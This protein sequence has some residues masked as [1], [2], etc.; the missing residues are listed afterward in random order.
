MCRMARSKP[1]SHPGSR[2]DAM[3]RGTIR[4]VCEKRDS[5]VNC[6]SRTP[7]SVRWTALLDRAMACR[8]CRLE[9]ESFLWLC[10]RGRPDMEGCSSM[11]PPTRLQMQSWR[12]RSIRPQPAGLRSSTSRKRKGLARS[13]RTSL[14][15]LAA[16]GQALMTFG[17]GRLT[18]SP[19]T[20]RR[21]QLAG[22]GVLCH[23]GRPLRATGSV[24]NPWKGWWRHS[25]EQNP[26]GQNPGAACRST[27][28]C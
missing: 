21:L 9:I 1:T 5:G 19:R 11:L 22:R 14:R 4:H 18:R 6:S 13:P 17:L 20:Q 25:E 7:L 28:T 16:N 24:G 2:F 10:R 26:S 3:A 12:R 27:G 23:P 8:C 15:S